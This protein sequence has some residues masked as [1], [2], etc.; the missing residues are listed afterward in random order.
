[1][2]RTGFLATTVTFLI[3]QFIVVARLLTANTWFPQPITSRAVTVMGKHSVIRMLLRWGADGAILFSVRD[4]NAPWGRERLG[5]S[6]AGYR[7]V[8][9]TSLVC[10][11]TARR[12]L[13]SGMCCSLSASPDRFV[14]LFARNPRPIQ[15]RSA[16][17]AA[18]LWKG[19]SDEQLPSILRALPRAR[20]SQAL[21][22]RGWRQCST[23]SHRAPAP[24]WI[25]ASGRCGCPS[26]CANDAVV[27][28]ATTNAWQFY[29]EVVPHAGRTVVAHPGLVKLIAT[30][31]VKTDQRD[32]LHLARLPRSEPDSRSLGAL[33]ARAGN[34]ARSWRIGVA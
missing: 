33:A 30:A 5:Q 22:R 15:L 21:R 18:A 28:E 1:M 27:L 34:C 26:T 4:G 13:S 25:S 10:Y 29:D 24:V 2:G 20:H 12:T 9:T 7:M 3:P 6:T 8:T 11:L 23:A 16:P 14:K 19:V 31:R 32:V 17:C